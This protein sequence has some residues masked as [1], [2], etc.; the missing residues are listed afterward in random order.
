MVVILNDFTTRA[1]VDIFAELKGKTGNMARLMAR[2]PRWERP[3][4]MAGM[5][6]M[7]MGGPDLNDIQYDALL[8]NRRTPRRS[9]GGSGAARRT[10]STAGSSREA[11]AT[12]F[13][14]KTGALRAEAVAVDG[15]DIVPLLGYRFRAGHRSAPRSAE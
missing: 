15:E 6:G 7:A 12:N 1:P 3:S 13:F 9:R 14:I 11:A 5:A 10:C 4:P 8:A 2:R